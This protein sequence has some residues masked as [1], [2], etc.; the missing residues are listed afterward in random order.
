M[1]RRLTK[2]FI[3]GFFYLLILTGITAGVYFGFLKPAPSCTDGKL[4]QNEEEVDCGGPNCADCALR[5]LKPL[6]VLPIELF[7]LGDNNSTALI[8]IQNLNLNYGASKFAY[9]L[10]FY[11]ASGNVV[12]TITDES[13]IYAGE[14]KNIVLAPLDI[15]LKNISRSELKARDFV[16]QKPDIFERP[17]MNAREVATKIE[18][19]GFAVQGVVQNKNSYSIDQAVVSAEV[20]NN[21]GLPI[22]ASKTFVA[23]LTPFEDRFFRIFIPATKDDLKNIDIKLTRVYIEARR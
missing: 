1:S 13:F 5:H 9:D 20:F 18:S 6:K 4:N 17:D 14:I 3:Y 7:P 22:G 8:Q 12:N 10:N 16:W 15:N 2:Q 19:T 21:T 23:D 11:D